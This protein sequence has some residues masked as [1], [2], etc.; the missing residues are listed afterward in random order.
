MTRVLWLTGVQTAH[1]IFNSGSVKPCARQINHSKPAFVCLVFVFLLC[2]CKETKHPSSIQ[3]TEWE[4]VSHDSA[5]MPL[6]CGNSPWVPLAPLLWQRIMN[7]YNI[8]HLLA[9]FGVTDLLLIRGLPKRVQLCSWNKEDGSHGLS[10]AAVGRLGLAR[11]ALHLLRPQ[12]QTAE[13]PCPS[14]KWNLSSL[15][16]CYTH[17]QSAKFF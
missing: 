17:S 16:T 12:I 1:F 8:C 14:L 7:F 6:S 10:G 11:P 9:L 4:A 13:T 2:I 15:L 5:G 3:S